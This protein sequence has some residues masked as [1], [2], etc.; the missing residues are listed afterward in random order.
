MI[1]TSPFFFAVSWNSTAPNITPWS[2][3]ATP[4]APSVYAFS[5][6][7]S[8]R[9]AP[10]SSE[11]SLWTCRWTKELTRKT[12]LPEKVRARTSS[13]SGSPPCERQ[14]HLPV[15]EFPFPYRPSRST[16]AA[17]PPAPVL[18]GGGQGGLRGV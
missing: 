8:T 4:G 1:G 11:Y 10:S 16:P 15:R 2:V 17:R 7:E 3:S 5:H 12:N 18:R 9:H 14:P 6:S 13:D